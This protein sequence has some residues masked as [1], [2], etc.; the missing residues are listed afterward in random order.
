VRQNFRNANGLSDLEVTYA[1][2]DT[3]EA[4]PDPILFDAMDNVEVCQD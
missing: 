1:G 2:I 4:A 3:V